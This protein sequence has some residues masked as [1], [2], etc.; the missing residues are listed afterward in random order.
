MKAPDL[1]Q[2][3]IL[4]IYAMLV[5]RRQPSLNNTL[6]GKHRLG[7]LF[8]VLFISRCFGTCDCRIRVPGNV[9]GY[10]QSFVISNDQLNCS[11]VLLSSSTN[12]ETA[13]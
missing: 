6:N 10:F 9:R 4:F 12:F 2:D 5:T 7:Q 1:A 11:R 3:C 8:K 13:L